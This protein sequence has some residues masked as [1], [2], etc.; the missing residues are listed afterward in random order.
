MRLFVVVLSAMILP[1]FAAPTS[2]ANQPKPNNCPGASIISTQQI[3]VDGN[4]VTLTHFS[5][6]AVTPAVEARSTLLQGRD[7]DEC[8]TSSTECK[9]GE[10]CIATCN[11]D[12][13]L[14][15]NP[16]NCATITQAIQIIGQINGIGLTFFVDPG[17]SVLFSFVDCAFE[18]DN[19]GPNTLEYCWDDFVRTENAIV[20]S[21]TGVNGNTGGLC[22]S[23]ANEWQS[24]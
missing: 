13:A 8:T 14:P 11:A 3:S 1:I 24:T 21:C 18:W 20:S 16:S 23:I 19:I 2:A 7:A 22:R 6:G 17:D 5:C 4:N 12:T 10:S 9:C 15:P